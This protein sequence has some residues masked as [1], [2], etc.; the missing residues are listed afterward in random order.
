[1]C[2][3]GSFIQLAFNIKTYD[4]ICTNSERSNNSTKLVSEADQTHRPKL[5]PV[6]KGCNT[7][8]TT[9]FSEW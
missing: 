9:L 8:M 2:F 6:M 1:M 4:T 7:L 5:H 3:N